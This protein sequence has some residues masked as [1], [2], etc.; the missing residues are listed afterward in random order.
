MFGK[1]FFK[2]ESSV[3]TPTI[4][5]KQGIPTTTHNRLKRL[6]KETTRF[7]NSS[8]ILDMLNQTPRMLFLA[9]GFPSIIRRL[10]IALIHLHQRSLVLVFNLH[11][12]SARKYKSREFKQPTQ[13]DGESV[14]AYHTKMRG[15]QYEMQSVSPV[16]CCT[17][18]K[19]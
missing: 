16:P 17:C 5:P 7:W 8:F 18:G 15:L 9:I 10:W 11:H 6:S 14:S 2:C 4:F 12:N 19:S 3:I 1:R 13:Q